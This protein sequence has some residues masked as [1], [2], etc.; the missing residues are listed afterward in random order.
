MPCCVLRIDG[1]EFDPDSFLAT[2][3]FVA[4]TIYRRGESRR[5]NS[6]YTASGFTVL[7]ND[8]GGHN[9]EEQVQEAIRYLHAHRDALARLMNHPGVTML[10]DFGCDFPVEQLAGRYYRLP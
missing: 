7:V 4:D 3:N 1:A 5:G 6:T 9:H 10:L 8:V 2:S